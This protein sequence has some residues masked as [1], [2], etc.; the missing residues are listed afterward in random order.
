MLIQPNCVIR[1]IDSV[2]NN[3]LS[4]TMYHFT[5]LPT[6]GAHFYSNVKRKQSY[7]WASTSTISNLNR[8]PFISKQ[9]NY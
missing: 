7:K 4:V 6:F 5:Y 2:E 9:G 8:V 1:L 3:S